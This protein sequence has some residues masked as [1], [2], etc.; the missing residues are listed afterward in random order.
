M[1]ATLAGNSP[2][3]KLFPPPHYEATWHVLPHPLHCAGAAARRAC[4]QRKRL[5][6]AVF[7]INPRLVHHQSRRSFELLH[8]FTISGITVNRTQSRD[9]LSNRDVKDQLSC[10][11]S[12]FPVPTMLNRHPCFNHINASNCSFNIRYP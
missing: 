4:H 10:K 6:G 1:A 8:F 2:Q 7:R 12:F 9:H 5:A 3:N 11:D